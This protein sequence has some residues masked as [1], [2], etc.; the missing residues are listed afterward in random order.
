MQSLTVPTARNP[1]DHTPAEIQDA[2]RGKTGSRLFT[3]RYELLDQSSR[4]V[5][6]LSGVEYCRI[7]QDWLA[8]IKRRASLLVRDLGRVDWL[9]DRI[10]PYVRLALPPYGPN[11]WVEWPQGVF[12]LSSPK[13]SASPAGVIS[14]PVEAYDLLQALADDKPATRYAV[15]A[16]TRY[17]D[18]VST[19]LTGFAKN[20]TASG[21]TLP[22]TREWE[23]GTSKLAIINDL[24]KAITYDSISFDEDGVALVRP[25]VV[26][27][28]RN[29]EFTYADGA[30]GLTIP[31]PEQTL[32]LFSVPNRWVLVSSD[33]DRPPMRAVYTNTDPSS[34]TSTVRRGRII[35]D[36]R[37]PDRDAP[38]TIGLQAQVQRLANE[39]SQ[40]Y[41]AIDFQ[42]AGMPIHSGNDSY[43]IKYGP[44]AINAQYIE[45]SWE[46]EMRANAPLSPMSHRARRVVSV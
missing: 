14:R 6:D 36:V 42:T 26:P 32:D 7:T 17:T 41:E 40:I 8:D 4:Y 29:S 23:P 38:D 2:L 39:A 28:K 35:T 5:E 30:D 44:L 27:S 45:Q 21:S 20:I 13:R 31:N 22:V 19:L 9:G 12:L 18:A 10:K 46:L 25:Y 3:Y 11:D 34:P 15:T 1:N 43:W 33:P 37:S 24:L 16:G